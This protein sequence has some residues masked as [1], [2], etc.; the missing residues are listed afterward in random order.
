MPGMRKTVD[1]GRWLAGSAIRVKLHKNI[2]QYPNY[3]VDA[4]YCCILQCNDKIITCQKTCEQLHCEPK[5]YAM[6]L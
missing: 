1:T 4:V 3:N 6:V 5:K 2:N